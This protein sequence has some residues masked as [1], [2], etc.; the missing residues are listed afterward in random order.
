[1]IHFAQKL[2]FIHV[3][4]TGG[5][6]IQSACGRPGW[7]SD[8]TKEHA[9][10]R[11]YKNTFPV[12]WETFHKV[13][14]H[15]DPETHRRSWFYFHKAMFV[16][17]M[18]TINYKPYASTYEDWVA[19]GCP[20][21]GDWTPCGIYGSPLNQTEFTGPPEEGVQILRYE[22]LAEDWARYVH[23]KNLPNDWA[24]L[25]HLNAASYAH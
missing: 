12:L 24:T 4:R 22:N 25:S 3:H 18:D 6:S 2:I 14:V 13:A 15:R 11:I 19:A 21:H 20:W 23:T 10:W 7:H 16:E 5:T 8:W 1:M 17:R 9:G